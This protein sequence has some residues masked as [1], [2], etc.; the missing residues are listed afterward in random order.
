MIDL[1]SDEKYCVPYILA[2]TNGI[3]CLA[4]VV[5]KLR[6]NNYLITLDHT[7]HND[8]HMKQY[9]DIPASYLRRE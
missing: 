4:Q 7:T 6:K 2:L 5:V 1:A 3:Q 8:L 9:K